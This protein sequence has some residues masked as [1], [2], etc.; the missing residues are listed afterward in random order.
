MTADQTPE[1]TQPTQR[2]E[3]DALT[4]IIAVQAQAINDMIISLNNL[5][6]RVAALEAPR[7]E[8]SANG[9]KARVILL[10]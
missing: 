8:P 9:D 10:Q 3:L 7:E 6:Q 4:E 2:L 1:S 5:Q